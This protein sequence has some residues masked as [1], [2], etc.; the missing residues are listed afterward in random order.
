M[1]CDLLLATPVALAALSATFPHGV[2]ENHRPY[3]PPIAHVPSTGANSAVLDNNTR[4]EIVYLKVADPVAP[5]TVISGFV[6]NISI[7]EERDVIGNDDHFLQEKSGNPWDYTGFL[8]PMTYE[9]RPN[10]DKGTRGYSTAKVTKVLLLPNQHPFEGPTN[11]CSIG[12]DWAILVFDTRIGEQYGYF[13]AKQIDESTSGFNFWNEVKQVLVP[14]LGGY[15]EKV[16]LL[17][18]FKTFSLQ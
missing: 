11:Y 8:D 16:F 3:T 6:A 4:P 12:Q 1:R 9:F 14:T 5:G 15:T 2:T 7:H 17:L 18:E 10:Y 13:G